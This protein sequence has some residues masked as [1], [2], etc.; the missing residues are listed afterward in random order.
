MVKKTVLLASCG[1]GL[2]R[3][4]GEVVF[5]I[6]NVGSPNGLPERSVSLLASPFFAPIRWA[7]RGGAGPVYPTDGWWW[8]REGT[9]S[10][11]TC[12]E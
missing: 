11:W 3:F 9:T 1:F 2:L 4:L 10:S 5:R 8:P 12:R 6:V 7:G